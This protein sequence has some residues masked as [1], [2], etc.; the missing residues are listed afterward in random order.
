MTLQKN[1]LCQQERRRK[2]LVVFGLGYEEG[3]RFLIEMRVN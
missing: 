1:D 2:V 3:I